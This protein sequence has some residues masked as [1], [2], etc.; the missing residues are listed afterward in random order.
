MAKRSQRVDKSLRF[1]PGWEK[2]VSGEELWDGSCLHSPLS[3]ANFVSRQ[4][5]RKTSAALKQTKQTVTFHDDVAL[6]YNDAVPRR[7]FP[8]GARRTDQPCTAARCFLNY[9]KG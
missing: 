1:A 4:G 5:S 7:L 9:A 3:C 2:R 8:V 6:H